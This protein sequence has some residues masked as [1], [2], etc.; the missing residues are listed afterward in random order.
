MYP[1]SCA[2][3]RNDFR[4][5]VALARV[6]D[7]NGSRGEVGLQVSDP[8]RSERP[9]DEGQEQPCLPAV[10]A[11]GVGA[12]VTAHPQVHHAGVGV[13][14]NDGRQSGLNRLRIEDRS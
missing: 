14:L 12:L 3:A 8:H 1:V 6:T 7:A 9:A 11:A 2:K 5:A 10:V 13:G 4:A